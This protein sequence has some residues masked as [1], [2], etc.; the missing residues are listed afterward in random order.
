M[1]QYWPM[2]VPIDPILANVNS[3]GQLLAY[4]I[5][6]GPILA[7]IDLPEL[8]LADVN[9]SGPILAIVHGSALKVKTKILKI[10]RGHTGNQWSS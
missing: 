5:S 4:I 10:T 6:I 9:C 7:N 1:D 8:I 3:F 2:L